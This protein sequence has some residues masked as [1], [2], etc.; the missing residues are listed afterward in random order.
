MVERG[1]KNPRRSVH[2]SEFEP[3]QHPI[4]PVRAGPDDW[5]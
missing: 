2:V 4:Y 5:G 3:L 1:S